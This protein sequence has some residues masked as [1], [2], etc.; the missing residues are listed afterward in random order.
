MRQKGYTLVELMVVVIIVAILGMIGLPS[1]RAYMIR[2]QRTE[3][4]DA[5]VRLAA[6]QEKFYFQNRTYTADL[7]R[8]GFDDA[9]GLTDTGLYEVAVVANQTTWSAT[10]VPAAGGGMDADDECQEFGIDETGARTAD[11]DPNDRCW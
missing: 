7:D 3:A 6:N 1:Y 5:L 11:P 10:A 8:L 2:S 9:T 4:K